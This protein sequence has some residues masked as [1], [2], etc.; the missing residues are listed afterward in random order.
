M[1]RVYII[2]GE[3]SGD[4]IGSELIKSLNQL[5][6][7]YYHFLGVGGELMKQQKCASLFPISEINLMGFIEIIPHIF[8][9]SKLIKLC[10]NHILSNAPDIIITIDSPGFTFRV[11]K[12]VRILNPNLKIIHIVAPSVWAYKP[13]RALKYAKIYDCL[14]TLLPFEPPYFEKVGLQSYFIGH[15]ILQQK[16]YTNQFDLREQFDIGKNDKVVCVTLGSRKAEI[17]R[18]APVVIQSLNNLSDLWSNLVIIFVVVSD[19]HQQLIMPFIQSVNFKFIFSNTSNKLKVFALSDVA[20]AKSGTNTLEIAASGI[21]MV[22]FYKVH[23][24]TYF[25]LKLFIKIKYISILNIIAGKMI[26]PELIQ[27]ECNITNLFHAV[28][29]LL[30]KQSIRLQQIDNIKNTLFDLG[31]RSNNNASI[32]AASIIRSLLSA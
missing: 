3:S 6:P 7:N 12:K 21:P 16:F 4:F 25:M 15:P 9:I 20:L 17:L 18:H 14:L 13:S 10:I 19:D 28:S 30:S 8:R 22:V 31:L 27:N 1:P 11:A 2:A 32:K 24:I 23:F 5:Q 29:E 26:V